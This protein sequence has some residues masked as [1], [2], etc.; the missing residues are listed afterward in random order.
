MAMDEAEEED[1]AFLKS[2]MQSDSVSETEVKRVLDLYR[3]Y[4]V[5]EL[6][7]DFAENLLA[8][9]S[10]KIKNSDLAEDKANLLINL[11][12]QLVKRHK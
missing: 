9:V 1:K 5:D 10:Q 2:V 7:K 4:H 11:A 12:D 6:V 8:E 3:L